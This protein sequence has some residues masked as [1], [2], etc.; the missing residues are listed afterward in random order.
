[1]DVADDHL[2]EGQERGRGVHRDRYIG[3]HRRRSCWRR[4]EAAR[5]YHSYHNYDIYE[6]YPEALRVTLT[7][8]EADKQKDDKGQ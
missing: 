7:I 3:N 2:V 4:I 5:S 1:M 8:F 6:N